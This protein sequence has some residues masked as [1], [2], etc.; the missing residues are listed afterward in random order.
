MNSDLHGIDEGKEEEDGNAIEDEDNED[1]D[2]SSDDDDDD[3]N[4][5]DDYDDNYDDK[6]S[7]ADK[8]SE[9]NLFEML[10][11]QKLVEDSLDR[12][13]DR[14]FLARED[15]M[16]RSLQL[17]ENINSSD[18]TCNTFN[19]SYNSDHRGVNNNDNDNNIN[20]TNSNT[21]NDDNNNNNSSNNNNNNITNVVKGRKPPKRAFLLFCQAIALSYSNTAKKRAE[22]ITNHVS[23][24]S[25]MTLLTS[26]LS[27][28]CTAI[29]VGST[30]TAI[31]NPHISTA[32]A[33]AAATPSSSSSSSSSIYLSGT[34][35]SLRTTPN[36]DYEY[37]STDPKSS[38]YTAALTAQSLQ[39]S[40][41]RHLDELNLDGVSATVARGA[42]IDPSHIRQA[43][44]HFGDEHVPL[45]SLLLT[46]GEVYIADRYAK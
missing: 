7:D 9:L 29:T 11:N 1:E 21:N 35:S 40:L 46:C 34:T 19:K 30:A 26:P 41:Q 25:N 17:L 31:S 39:D 32:A 23:S 33:A 14:T 8:K 15:L 5:N 42:I 37:Q 6:H 2:D 12:L 24:I 16:T 44:R 3:D 18:T 43:G 10:S 22:I 45:F 4:D 38:Q 27:L 20:N 13:E 28:S 36:N